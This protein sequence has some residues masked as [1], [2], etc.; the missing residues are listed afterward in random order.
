MDG[1]HRGIKV[2]Q[3]KHGT[4]HV[5]CMRGQHE[6]ENSG[7]SSGRVEESRKDEKH[8][9]WKKIFTWRGDGLVGAGEGDKKFKD[10]FFFKQDE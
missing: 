1:E 3:R 5:T 6:A 4:G 8:G 7:G 2:G 9:V 10:S